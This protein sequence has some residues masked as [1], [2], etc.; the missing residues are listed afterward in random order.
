[1]PARVISGPI[2]KSSSQKE[3]EHIHA[4]SKAPNEKPGK[5]AS[6]LCFLTERR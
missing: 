3:K 4:P 2:A 6:L 1:M 5:P